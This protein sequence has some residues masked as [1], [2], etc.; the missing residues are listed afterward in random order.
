LLKKLI[1]LSGM[2]VGSMIHA[3]E[4]YSYNSLLGIEAGGSM[5]TLEETTG[6]YS[7]ELS[8]GNIGIKVGAESEQFRVFLGT[9]YYN[10]SAFDY[11]FTYGADLQYLVNI[12][13]DVNIFLGAGIG[14]AEIKHEKN[15]V[16][17][18]VSEDYISGDLGINI[19]LDQQFDLELGARMMNIDAENTQNGATY[20][21]N[22]IYTGYGSLIYKF[23]IE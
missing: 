20:R 5:I 15:S 17:R 13:D 16:T 22:E 3:A 23:S 18:E 1:V 10:S 11:I 21:Y 7:S 14:K 2:L 19:H 9:R 12:T 8:L 6:T 4:D